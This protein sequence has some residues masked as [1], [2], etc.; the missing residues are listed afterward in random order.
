LISVEKWTT[1]RNLA[2][3]GYGKKAIARMLKV[4]RNTVRKALST[5]EPPQYVRRVQADTLIAPYQEQI[6]KM[7][8]EKGLI[9]TRIYNELLKLG[10][11]GSLTTLYRYLG[12]LKKEP[13]EKVTVRFET[14]P[15]FQ[16]QFDWSP[17]KALIA[18]REQLIY[19]FLLILSYSRYK[20]MTFSLDQR[21]NSVLEALEKGLNFFGGVPLQILIDNAKQMVLATLKDNIKC[22]HESFL[23]LAGMYSFKPVACQIRRART[24][25]KVERPFYTVE[26]HFIKGNEF[27]SMDDLFAR[28]HKFLEEWNLKEH[29]TTLV[30]PAE[31]FL[32]E[33]ELLLPLPFRSYCDSLRE[34]RKVSWDCL[35]SVKGSRYSVPSEYAGKKVF[36][37][38]EHG[39]LLKVFALDGT[40][41]CSHELSAKKGTT[42][43]KQ[44]HY[45]ALR[46][47]PK[48]TPRIREVFS[49]TFKSGAL[50]YQGLQNRVGFNAAY[51]AQKI[52]LL[53]EYYDDDT[54]EQSLFKALSFKAFSHEVVTNILRQYPFKET[55]LR[56]EDNLPLEPGY[57]PRSLSYY[58]ALIH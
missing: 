49:S 5:D 9:G 25:G 35:I 58:N 28:G 54:I 15:A 13:Q 50:F 26:Q 7:Y 32:K 52:L 48:S 45:A 56:A 11:T 12:T 3:E 4:S 31:L 1:I 27:S 6:E 21:L 29:S 41:L 18:G 36:I 44:E 57:T 46:P 24:K 20:Y 2:R 34:L 22:F 33:K 38:I 8:L 30:P 17:Y 14:G 23:A 47:A 39:Y 37:Q 10:Y 55:A 40:Q 51:H 53:R 42:N 43:I 19:C 16:A